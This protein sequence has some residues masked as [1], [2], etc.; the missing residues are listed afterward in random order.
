MLI[1]LFYS[2]FISSLLLFIDINSILYLHKKIFFL[3]DNNI[4]FL[5]ILIGILYK[6]FNKIN[7]K[8]YKKC[9]VYFLVDLFKILFL[10]YHLTIILISLIITFALKL[11]NIKVN[12]KV[13]FIIYLILPISSY[14]ILN[15]ND[16]N[17]NKSKIILQFDIIV[18]TIYFI[19]KNNF[20]INIYNSLFFLFIT[21]FSFFIYNHKYKKRNILIIFLFIMYLLY[22]LN[23]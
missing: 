14:Y 4:L 9:I 2:I 23:C 1:Y 7:F 21:I 12:H 20:Y 10:N 16:I 6:L 8:E 13:L 17:I 15:N 22:Y 11:F 18:F 3:S 19:I 5:G